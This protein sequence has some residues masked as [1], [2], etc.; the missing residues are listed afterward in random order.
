MVG[1]AWIAS[2]GAD[3]LVADLV[4]LLQRKCVCV[5]VF[6]CL[7][8]CVC[9]CVCVCLYSLRVFSQRLATRESY[10][11]YASEP[12]KRVCVCVFIC[13]EASATLS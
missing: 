12:K 10:S 7:F 3:A 8:V 11:L 4:Q 5:C 1:L 6:V 13:R 2:G 9:V